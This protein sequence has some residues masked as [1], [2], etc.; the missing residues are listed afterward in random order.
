MKRAKLE[1]RYEE[2]RHAAQEAVEAREWAIRYD[3][4]EPDRPIQTM[5]RLKSVL[6]RQAPGYKP[7][8][9]D[10]QR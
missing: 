4:G 1:A 7:T 5:V 6:R 9:L 2:L 8:W 3:H 10:E